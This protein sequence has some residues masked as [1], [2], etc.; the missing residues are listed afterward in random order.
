[1][2][3]R[4]DIRAKVVAQRT[5]PTKKEW[6]PPEREVFVRRARKILAFDQTVNHTG[7]AVLETVTPDEGD[8]GRIVVR[9][10]GILEP[11][12]DTL[13][14]NEATLVR[15]DWMLDN[16][17]SMM[18]HFSAPYHG[19]ERVVYE[20][21][22]AAGG[23]NRP[24]SILLGALAVRRAADRYG[25]PVV[26]MSNTSM[27]ALLLPREQRAEKKYVGRAVEGLLDHRE[28]G[29]WN[30]HIKDSVALGLTYIYKSGVE[31]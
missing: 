1:M 28:K 29:P 11:P 24:E 14:G 23:Y 26:A 13:A 2:V 21:P 31:A 6:T 8:D 9:A 22:I 4:D 12:K 19:I 20:M 15:A 10:T 16:I 3:T 5:R 25:L 7:W 30:E 17:A 18:S 27:K